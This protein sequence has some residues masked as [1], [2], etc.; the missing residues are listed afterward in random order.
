MDSMEIQYMQAMLQ[1][2]NVEGKLVCTESDEWSGMVTG[3]DLCPR[4][5]GEL[6]HWDGRY[7]KLDAVT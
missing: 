5:L 6:C 7:C 2:K 3:G 4:G 1:C